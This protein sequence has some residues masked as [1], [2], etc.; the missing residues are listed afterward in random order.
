MAPA[1][2]RRSECHLSGGGARGGNGAE[3]TR[4]RREFWSSG[5]IILGHL[6]HR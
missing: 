6:I 4:R 3:G 2:S 1:F 5:C